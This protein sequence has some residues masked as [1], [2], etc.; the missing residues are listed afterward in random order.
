MCQKPCK[1]CPFN[2]KNVLGNGSEAL[3]GSPPEVYVGQIEGPF[4]LPCHMDNRY[5]GKNTDP[6]DNLQ[7]AGAAIYRANIQV[8]N[9]MPKG[10]LRLEPET[11]T[12]FKDH[13][14]FLMHYLQIT[15][16]QANSWLEVNDP[17]DLMMEEFRKVEVKRVNLVG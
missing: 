8:A 7:C 12:V 10:L 1:E 4:W 15:R 6:N 14:E 9:K 2:K 16:E 3:G 13:Q 17:M 5:R 11:E